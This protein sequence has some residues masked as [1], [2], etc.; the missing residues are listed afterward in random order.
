MRKNRY[1][2]LFYHTLKQNIFTLNL[3]IGLTVFCYI[4]WTKF[5]RIRLPK[6]IDEILLI[7]NIFIYI[8]IFFLSIAC[9]SNIIF[10]IKHKE[11]PGSLIVNYTKKIP[12]IYTIFDII[13]WIFHNIFSSPKLVYKFIID[14]TKLYVI[15][16]PLFCYLGEYCDNYYKNKNKM[17]YHVIYICFNMLPKFIIAL[18]FVIEIIFYHKLSLFYKALFL[19]LIPFLYNIFHFMI[20]YLCDQMLDFAN[21]HILVGMRNGEEVMKFRTEVPNIPNAVDIVKRKYD[22]RLLKW[23]IELYDHYDIIKILMYHLAEVR[24]VI[25]IYETI[26]ICT[27]YLIGWLYILI[28]SLLW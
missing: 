4:F 19:Y 25:R 26:L 3:I 9:I 20:D 11:S 28:Y 14:N 1:I 17:I 24:K 15:I 8:N 13:I 2:N 22:T 18:I 21:A 12:Y 23:F 5:L 10:L 16:E 27:L 6:N 7:N